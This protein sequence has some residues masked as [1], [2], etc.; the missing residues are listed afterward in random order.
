MSLTRDE[1]VLL[2]EGSIIRPVSDDGWFT[3]ALK[4]SKYMWTLTGYSHTVH[5]THLN[6][7]ADEWEKVNVS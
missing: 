4:V 6:R 5:S 7:F 2:P 1:L 3:V